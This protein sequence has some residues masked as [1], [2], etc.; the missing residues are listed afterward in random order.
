MTT[1]RPVRRVVR[2]L[3]LPATIAWAIAAGVVGYPIAAPWCVGGGIVAMLVGV[4]LRVRGTAVRHRVAVQILAT[5]GACAAVALAIVMQAPAH[6]PPPPTADPVPVVVRV[7]AVTSV[8]ARTGAP[9]TR[10]MVRGTL[11]SIGEPVVRGTDAPVVVFPDTVTRAE[12]TPG[13]SIGFVG[14]VR[15]VEPGFDAA[16]VSVV[17]SIRLTEPA[18]GWQQAAADLRAGLVQRAQTLPGDGG[19]LLPGLAIGDT[20]HVDETLRDA[21]RAA[22]LSHLTA[23]SGANCAVV[24][25]AVF[26]VAGLLRLRRGVRVAVAVAALAGFVV[27]VTPQPSVLR[28]AVMALVAL[29]CL[30]AGRRVAGPPVLAVAVLVLLVQDPWMALDAG[31]VLSVLATAGLLLLTAPIADALEKVLPRRLALVLAVPIAAQLACQPVLILLQP[32]VPVFGVLANLLAE[33]AAPLVTVLGLLACLL[34]PVVPPLGG[35]LALLGWVPAAWIAAV[36]RYF[37]G[38]P[39]VPWPGG[40]LG[41][42]LA[43]AVVVAGVVALAHRAGRV[44]RLVAAGSVV[45]LVVGMVGWAAGG[46]L[47]RA[48]TRPPDWRFAACDVGQGDGLVLN[49]GG[50]H[51]VAIDTG[52]A[53]GPMLHCLRDLGVSNLDLLILTHWDADHVGGV[54]ALIGRVHTA[55]VGPDS[56]PATVALR[57][58]LRAGGVRMIAAHRGMVLDVG[59]LHVDVL[60]PP[61][62]FRGVPAGA[63]STGAVSTGT[64]STGAMSTGNTAS[65]TTLVT[66]GLSGLFAG[67]LDEATENA[68]MALGPLPHVDVVKV[69]H[70]GSAN[71]SASFY[72]ALAAPVGLISCGAGNDYH[73][74]T[75]RLLAMLRAAGTQPIRTD[76]DG[77]IL[78]SPAAGGTARVWTERPV[79]AAVWTPAE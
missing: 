13:A 36:A 50:G 71:N 11:A 3:V 75:A 7:E 68:I 63:V 54:R 22:S 21:M 42:L 60:W 14:R 6:R 72:R 46:A 43:V 20:G 15:P 58:D 25:V 34:L 35:A 33:P 57:R 27:L 53:P 32:T 41:L 31:F 4:L 69:A 59:S 64:V 40:V 28:A 19:V 55:L 24:T 51:Y 79:T 45:L 73:H 23:V 26:A 9:G 74:P 56:R 77:M 30:A 65:V 44:V 49:G 5:G 1:V 18:P 10:L 67:D 62:S 48:V 17:G 66:G 8:P 16:T 78:V 47:A 38:L 39:A 61:E 2:G 37:A 52:P 70:H 29:G 76:E 12:R